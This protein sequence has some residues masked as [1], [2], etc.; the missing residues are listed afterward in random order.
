M[1]S[2]PWAIKVFAQIPFSKE[3]EQQVLEIFLKL[4]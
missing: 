1:E 2:P 3:Y 4:F